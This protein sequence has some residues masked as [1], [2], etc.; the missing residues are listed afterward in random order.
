MT[1]ELLPVLALML[2]LYQKPRSND[3]FQEYLKILRG[4]LI[5]AENKKQTICLKI[6]PILE[7]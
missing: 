4:C 5:F 3:R 2:N 6:K 7:P 1:F